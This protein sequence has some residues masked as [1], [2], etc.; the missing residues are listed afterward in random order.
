MTAAKKLNNTILVTSP[1]EHAQCNVLK[2]IS[3]MFSMISAQKAEVKPRQSRRIKGHNEAKF[4]RVEKSK[5]PRVA[6]D[7]IVMC[8]RSVVAPE[9][10]R[11]LPP[12]INYT[13]KPPQSDTPVANTRSRRFSRMAT[14]EAL[15]SAIKMSST[16]VTPKMISA[17]QLPMKLLCEMAGAVMD[18][19]G[20]FLE[21][22]Q[23]MKRDEYHV[24]RVKYL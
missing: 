18:L 12:T 19:S 9:K 17:R 22:I 1:Q 23:L 21:Y 15:L 16:K 11:P 7:L 2:N 10:N 6:E 13:S 14:Q 4:P 8:P 24:I 5:I 3:D 20:E